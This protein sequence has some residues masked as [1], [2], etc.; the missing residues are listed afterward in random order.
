MKSLITGIDLK[1][2]TYL[3]FDMTKEAIIDLRI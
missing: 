2:T 3:S 1:Q